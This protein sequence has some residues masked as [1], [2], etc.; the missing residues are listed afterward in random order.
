[1][2]DLDFS[3]DGDI[4]EGNYDNSEE[5]KH[6]VNSLPSEQ[7]FKILTEVC[8][9]HNESISSLMAWENYLTWDTINPF[10]PIKIKFEPIEVTSGVFDIVNSQNIFLNKVIQAFTILGAEIHNLIGERDFES[11]YPLVIYGENTTDSENIED[12]EAEVQIARMLPVFIS[13]FEKV[14]KLVPLALNL[15]NQML[16]LYNKNFKNYNSSFKNFQFFKP[17]EYISVILGYFNAIDITYNEN[18]NLKNH[19]RLYKTMLFRT[20]DNPV[21]FGYTENQSTKLK[22]V[23]KKLDE[24]VLSGRLLNSL[25]KHIITA[26]GDQDLVRGNLIHALNNKEY[27]S[28]LGLYL[29]TKVEKLQQEITTL[30]ETN[31]KRQ[32]FNLY[33]L[34]AY[35]CRLFESET[36]VK[37]QATVDKD[38][39]KLFWGVQKKIT[40]FPLILHINFQIDEFLISVSTPSNKFSEKKYDPKNS[41]VLKKEQ[42]N[43]FM[44]N[45]GN[46]VH[47]LKLEVM[48]WITRTD[49]ATFN[50]N[51]KENLGQ[52]NDSRVKLIVNGL[53][54][55]YQL[56]NSITYC[57]NTHLKEGADLKGKIIPSICMNLSLIKLIELQF[58]RL[59]SKIALFYD[60]LIRV[61]YFNIKQILETSERKN[62]TGNLDNFK[63]DALAALKIISSN[64]KAS[65]SKLR[66]LINELC[67]DLLKHKN[68]FNSKEVEDLFFNFWRVGLLQQLDS[69]IDSV[70]DTSFFYWYKDV[71]PECFTYFYKHSKSL[72]SL[73]FFTLAISD[74]S[75]PLLH[76][77][78]LQDNTEVLKAYKLETKKKLIDNIFHKFAMDIE[79]ELRL[80]IHSILIKNLTI[81]NPNNEGKSINFNDVLKLRNVFLFENTLCFKNYVQ[82]YLNKIFYDMTTLNI[83]DWKTYQQMRTLAKSKYN[84]NLHDIHLPSQTLEQGLDII[85]ILRNLPQFV[86]NYYYNLHSQIFIEITKDNNYITVIGMQQI[87]N[88]LNT[89]G[90]GIVNSIVNKIYHFTINRLKSIS[91]V[92]NDE[93]IKS[94][95]IMEKRYWLENKEDLQN[96]YPYERAE[97]IMNDIK[98]YGK[99]GNTNIIDQLKNCISHVGNALGYVRTLKSALK[100]F[101]SQSLK[102]FSTNPS[103]LNSYLGKINNPDEQTKKASEIFNDTLN[104]LQTKEKKSTNYLLLLVNLFDN[105]FTSENIPD[106]DLFFYL[107]PALTISAAESL[108]VAKDKL[109]KKNNK[110]AYISDDGFII[111]LTY[112]IKVFGLEQSFNSLHWF[113]SAIN[114]FKNEEISLSSKKTAK[115]V[116]LQKN[117]SLKKAGEYKKE[118]ELLMFTYNSSVILFNDY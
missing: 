65:P 11:L 117:M 85:Y 81:P 41:A 94:S 47:N 23:I 111:G 83:N 8:N 25:I 100:E 112:I 109:H 32:L 19:W 3:D 52:T 73:F 75:K 101:Q 80:H 115:D 114:K 67:F 34:F 61:L 44:V 97:H 68:F 43:Q 2:E 87:L 86:Q 116:D 24:S 13:L 91:N 17:F 107:M 59:Q 53:I 56:K 90:I 45:Y 31:E 103:V 20:N 51:V 16:A 60:S 93:Y 35:Y 30:T 89:H 38:L 29:K 105:I 82:E 74:T 27:C 99:T 113:E 15:V 33:S 1:M 76:I 98:Q 63:S 55:A 12:G 70:C 48:T 42:L 18:E 71:V 49:S 46:F 69:E 57:M 62:F 118:F 22:K 102:Y 110:E 54:L 58:K 77:R 95:L 84:L 40:Q 104:L 79:S 37:D 66:I 72:D 64:L 28:H 96:F 26:T 9:K 4:F 10:C 7:H 50:T 88:S 39:Y 106:I 78:Y 6:I 21:K 5:K 14:K 108:I 36:K 92:I